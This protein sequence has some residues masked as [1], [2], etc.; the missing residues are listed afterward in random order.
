MIRRGLLLLLAAWFVMAPAI[1]VRA[2][3]AAD[4]LPDTLPDS[5]GPDATA[6]EAAPKAEAPPEGGEAPPEM[7]LTGPGMEEEE[8]APAEAPAPKPKPKPKPVPKPRPKP[9]PIPKPVAPAGPYLYQ[10]IEDFEKLQVGEAAGAVKRSGG[11]PR[12]Q[13]AVKAA[14]PGCATARDLKFEAVPALADGTVWSLAPAQPLNLA[15]WRGIS[16]RVKA[17]QPVAEL[18][19][20]VVAGGYVYRAVPAGTDWSEVRLDFAQDPGR[21]RFDPAAIKEI[22]VTASHEG[23]QPVDVEIDELAAWKERVPSEPL[24]WGMNVPPVAGP[25]DW[26]ADAETVNCVGRAVP[27][28]GF[29]VSYWSGPLPYQHWPVAAIFHD[30]PHGFLGALAVTATVKADPVQPPVVLKVVLQE[31]GGERFAAVRE[32]TAEAAPLR[33]P[34]EE[35]LP[36]ALWNVNVL[37]ANADGHLDPGA[38]KEWRVEILA[39]SERQVKGTLTFK[40]VRAVGPELARPKPAPPAPKPRPKPVIRKPEP[41]PEAAPEPAAEEPAPADESAPAEP[42]AGDDMELSP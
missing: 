13:F 9:K 42:P 21:G 8:A 20:G 41:K 38:V 22:L 32:A 19:I 33:I 5:G 12:P 3:D 24:R 1:R 25:F 37:P 18:R 35:F 15:G 26:R 27:G 4:G 39:A 36:D 40:D 34:L 2:D 16:L 7:E 14:T 17:S 6:A 11:D 29:V 10:M 23:A 31:E 28:E 30:L